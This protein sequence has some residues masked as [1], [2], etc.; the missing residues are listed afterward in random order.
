MATQHSHTST[1]FVFKK[2]QIIVVC[3]GVLSPAN[4][5]ALFRVCDALGIEKIIFCSTT[6]DFTSARL[7]R[8]SRSTHQKVPY[9][10]KED[11]VLELQKLKEAGYSLLALE[12]TDNSISLEKLKLTNKK[13]ALVIG[14]EQQGISKAVLNYISQVIHIEM[15]GE[16]S[17]MNVVQA[18]GIALYSIVNKLKLSIE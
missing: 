1:P 7:Q 12:V 11:I 8:T 10:I 3:D 15:Y 13:V 5:G 6:I 16:N 17:S 4:V 18:S 2:F 14:N 9:Y